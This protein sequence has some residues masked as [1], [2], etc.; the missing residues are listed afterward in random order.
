MDDRLKFAAG[1]LIYVALFALVWDGRLDPSVFV[2][3]ASAGL[4]ALGIHAAVTTP[5]P[6][7][8]N[9]PVNPTKPGPSA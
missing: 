8:G 7:A 2:T 6:P 5:Y 4:S 1:A 9:P 3:L